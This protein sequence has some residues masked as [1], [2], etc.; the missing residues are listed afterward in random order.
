[1]P[2]NQPWNK[3]AAGFIVTVAHKTFAANNNP[4]SYAEHDL[5]LATSYLLLQ[6]SSMGIYT[7]PMAGIDKAKLTEVLHL[8]ENQAPLCIIALGY[9]DDAEKL[10]E[11]FKGR[12]LAPRVRK[13]LSEIAREV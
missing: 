5:G 6:A 11:P 2:G 7:H 1:M 4:N 8:T 12:E 9:L 3:H 13:P 10:E